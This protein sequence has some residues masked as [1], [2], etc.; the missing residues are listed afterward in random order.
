ML[1]AGGNDVKATE[2]V[3]KDPY[4]KKRTGLGVWFLRLILLFL[5][6][7][8]C[9]AAAF[10]LY[11]RWLGDAQ[12]EAPWAA[13]G[14]ANLNPVQ[15]LYLQTYLASR[16]DQLDE[17]IGAGASPVEF[18][19]EPGQSAGG[20]AADLAQAGLMQDTALFLN[21]LRFQGLD[22]QLEA[23]AYRIDPGWNIPELALALTQSFG[24]EV[25]LRFL[26]GWRVEEMAAYLSVVNAA[27]VDG[28]AFLDIALRRAPFDLS[29]HSFLTEALPE[30]A[31]LEGFLFPDTYRLP[32]DADAAFL[33]DLMLRNFGE[34]VTP[35]LREALAGNDL[36]LYEAV[37][38][39]SIVEREA[40]LTSE[41]PRVAAVFYNRLAQDMPLQADP[42]VQYAVGFDD[43][44]NTWWKSQL[45]QT[46]LQLPSPY[47]TYV[48]RGL[49]PGPIANPGLAS[50]EAVAYPLQSNE[51]FFVADC[52][53][54]NGQE[55]AHLFSETYAEHLANVERCR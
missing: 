35:G 45:T 1:G 13:A 6:V 32:L 29:P 4:E 24:Q 40:P 25:E 23:G 52:I 53:G 27:N 20:I 14:A 18:T 47:N 21:Y 51:L 28:A 37:T 12:P 17:P 33:V 15:R 10:L 49:P 43:A 9:A 26:E 39:A 7:T 41:R 2:P 36:S 55:G 46:D 11:M 38:L 16:A 42:T 54:Q 48:N 44:S 31:S 30:N 19:V 3:R 8:V 5:V 34:K 50:L 22:S